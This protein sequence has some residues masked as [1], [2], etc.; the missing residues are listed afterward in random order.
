MPAPNPH[1]GVY[2][3]TWLRVSTKRTSPASVVDVTG[4]PLSTNITPA[5][6]LGTPTAGID[7]HALPPSTM[8]FLI[9]TP[10]VFSTRTCA[11]VQPKTL[12]LYPAHTGGAEITG[13]PSVRLLP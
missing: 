5:I 6:R 1:V 11:A 7:G 13:V 2:T 8:M 3:G 10:L 9:C 12:L 4:S